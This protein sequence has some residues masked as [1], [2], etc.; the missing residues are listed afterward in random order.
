GRPPRSRGGRRGRATRA[1]AGG[2][3]SPPMQDTLRLRCPSRLPTPSRR[4]SAS[5]RSATS[6]SCSRTTFDPAALSERRRALEEQM[7][8]PG[9]WDDSETAAKVNTEHAQIS[10][11]LDEFEGLERDVEDLVE[12]GDDPD[13][14][15][16]IEEQ[17]GDVERRLEHLEE[18]RLFSGRY[19]PG[20]ALVTVN[21]GAG[22][23]DAQDWAEMVLRMEM[24]WAEKRGF[25][26]E[27]LEASPGEE[28]GIKSATFLV[29]GENAYGLYASEKGVHR[30]VR[31]SPFDAAH[32]RQTSFAGVEVSPVVDDID[33]V[34]I[35][36]D[37]L[38]VDTYRASGAG[39]QHVNKTDSAVRITHKPTGIV[40]QCQNERSQS[41]NKATAMAMLRSKLLELEERK[42]QEELARERGEAQAAG[43]GSQ[44][45]PCVLHPYTM[46]KDHRTNE[47]MGDVQR[48]LDGDLDR[49][50]RAELARRA[51]S[52]ST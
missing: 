38:Q 30:L 26:V 43:W 49:F 28:A 4:P 12:L 3:G 33:D 20:D 18:Q 11:K 47:E 48:V 25:G 24:R 13:L 10:R 2:R 34:Q 40:V 6:S 42:R 52:L 51:G 46:V 16:E 21:A 23:T 17:L 37:D 8:A 44:M 35:D 29:K 45:R 19:D 5:R 14:A 9:F 1:A 39:G 41:S 7:Q 32:R 31:L 22:G 36:E 15:G 50:I 27:L